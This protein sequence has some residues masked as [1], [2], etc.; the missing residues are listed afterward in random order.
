MI[1]VVA[2]AILLATYAL[3]EMC[4][5]KTK[6]VLSTTLVM[7]VVLLAA[8]WSG[9]PSTIFKD[10]GVSQIGNII[11]VMLIVSLGTTID[12]AELKR[13]WKVVVTGFVCVAAAVALIILVGGP[14]MGRELAVAGSPIFAGGSAA[15]LI[16]TTALKERGLESLSTFCIALY[17]TQKF[18]GIPIAS[19]LLRREAKSFLKD[20][21]NLALYADA[22]EL[23]AG[24]VR[25]R[26]LELPAAFARPSVYLAKLALVAVIAYFASKLTHDYVHF[27]VMALLMGI[28]FCGLGFLEKDI[29]KKSQAS[30]LI[31]FISTIVIFSNLAD[32][33]PADV[34]AVIGPLLLTA[35]LGTAGV[36]LAG[37]ACSKALH[38]G[39]GLAV[40]M[41]IS[42]TF[43]FPTTMLIPQEVAEA[44][45]TTP[46]EKTALTNYLLPKMLTAG[47]VTVTISSVLLAGVVVNLL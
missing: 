40:S 16:M 2:M 21:D 1:P 8:F 42:C 26:P 25:R 39:L 30:S 34:A 37:L 6:A 10:A 44:F 5:Q 27:F 35:V 31:T 12:F 28:L 14:L 36:F 3:G 38:M 45:G 43:G 11:A 46:E 32:T 9:L 15:T 4:A 20:P 7:A 13:Q 19:L 41:G 29:L 33:T 47:F 18:I 24:S 17:V 23:P 22:P